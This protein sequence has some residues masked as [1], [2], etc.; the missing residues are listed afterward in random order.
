MAKK[1]LTSE[2]K[3]C[4]IRHKSCKQYSGEEKTRIGLDVLRGED[5]V[6]EL[7]RREGITESMYYRWGKEF[8]EAGKSRLVGNNKRQATSDEV[9]GLL[10]YT[11]V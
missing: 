10:L 9:Q 11:D 6:G 5:S 3:V 8:Q 4:Q 7:C 1:V 2:K